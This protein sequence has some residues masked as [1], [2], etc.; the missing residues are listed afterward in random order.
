MSSAASTPPPALDLAGNAG[1]AMLSKAL[2]LLTRLVVPPLVLAHVTLAEYG[3]W[4]AAFVL[5]MY[6]GLTDAGFSTVYVR[7]AA[8]FHASGELTA[9]NRLLSTGM[10][11][12]GG[13]SLLVLA[14][15]ALVLPWLLE[16][17]QVAAEYRQMATVL[18]LGSAAMF[19]LDLTLGAYCYLLHALQRIR[20]EQRVAMAGYLAELALIVLFLKLGL[21]V[22][23]LLLAFV[24]RYTGS[25]LAFRRLAHRFLP[26]LALSPRLFDRVMLRH[27]VGYGGTVQLSALAATVLFS[28]DRLLAG[29]LL[30]PA[31]IAL[32]ELAAKLPVSALAVPAAISNVTLAGAARLDADSSEQGQ[33]A[34]RH[35]YA[36]ATRATALVAALPL[37]FLAAFASPIALT[38]LGPRAELA[39]LPTLLTL[40]CLSAQLHISTGPG[41]AVLRACGQ[42]RNE[43]IYHGLRLAALALACPL[44]LWLLAPSQGQALALGIGLCAGGSVAALA[45]LHLVQARLGLST[46]ELWRH[47]LLP[48]A[49]AYPLAWLLRQ[50]WE[51]LWPLLWPQLTTAP[52]RPLAILALAGLAGLHTLLCLAA[53]WW[54]LL[55]PGEKEKLLP[56]CQ[57]LTNL[58]PLSWRKV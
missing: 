16:G 58:R 21:G 17:L 52:E 33:A 35:L 56:L 38:W 54:L 24:L 41:S 27:F 1:I 5:I 13:L 44:S 2:Y 34:V 39:L 45:Y 11:L 9:I 53:A 23:A 55:T 12:L 50:G 10:V 8:R 20:E 57:R 29:G 43:F 37:S 26:G 36:Q 51:G 14:G 18:M 48:A 25:L 19:L 3:L 31:G 40:A 6:V 42:A 15:L 30:G 32:F 28:A 22:Y 4:T 47:S 49:L 46:G 7:F